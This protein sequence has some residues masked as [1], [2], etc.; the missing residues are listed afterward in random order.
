MSGVFKAGS[1]LLYG[2]GEDIVYLL[3]DDDDV[4]NERAPIRDVIVISSDES[5]T[6]S[7]HDEEQV[8]QLR[9]IS[10]SEEELNNS[11]L[12]ERLPSLAKLQFP[13]VT[14]GSPKNVEIAFA[15]LSSSSTEAHP[16]RKRKSV[17]DTG[18][19]PTPSSS[20][21]DTDGALVD[22][23]WKDVVASVFAKPQKNTDNVPAIKFVSMT[24]NAAPEFRLLSNFF[25]ATRHGRSVEED[26]IFA[27]YVNNTE[28]ARLIRKEFFD[29]RKL[30]KVDSVAG[31]RRFLQ[32]FQPSKKNWTE[33]KF[34]YW[35]LGDKMPIWGVLAKLVAGG[36]NNKRRAKAINEYLQEK[37]K[38]SESQLI[39]YPAERPP[40]EK[41]VQIMLHFLRQKFKANPFLR[42]LL[43]STGDKFMYECSLRGGKVKEIKNLNVALL[44]LRDEMNQKPA[45]TF[46]HHLTN[47]KRFLEISGFK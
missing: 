44:M 43:L 35:T 4:R 15:P 13:F 37:Y 21:S 47:L 1:D 17:S 41:S 3:S 12:P 33:A 5:E 32:L 40:P 28:G 36:H 16:S 34:R 22:R 20:S 18:S 29:L 25:G 46:E 38:L 23:P 30:P 42:N 7:D 8:Y 39:S 45:K 9:K 2:E 26:Y 19:R 10:R 24:T 27:T 14:Q 6:E 11:E 31:F